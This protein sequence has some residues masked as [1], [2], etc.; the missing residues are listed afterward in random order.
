[1]NYP[2]IEKC[3]QTENQKFSLIRL[4]TTN[5]D[6]RFKYYI[7]SQCCEAADLFFDCDF[8]ITQCQ[9]FNIR[10][11]EDKEIR[12]LFHPLTGSRNIEYLQKA[13]DI[14]KYMREESNIT[15]DKYLSFTGF[16]LQC[17]RMEIIHYAYVVFWNYS[18]GY[19]AHSYKVVI[20]GNEEK[21][22]KG[23]V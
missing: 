2:T 14:L 6:Y 20:P 7:E 3:E 12:S 23:W 5:G 16:E 4:T 1:M 15:S 8:E 21:I 9:L 17:R 10:Q 11:I 22:L 19:Y 13:S 18:N